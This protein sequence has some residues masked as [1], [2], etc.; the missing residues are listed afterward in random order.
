MN[1]LETALLRDDIT[2]PA[3]FWGGTVGRSSQSGAIDHLVIVRH[4]LNHGLV[5]LTPTASTRA[6]L[7]MMSADR[8]DML[9]TVSRELLDS[10][11][12]YVFYRPGECGPQQVTIPVADLHD[13]ARFVIGEFD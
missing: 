9:L 2:S 5:H 4:T 1:A 13:I 8:M 12:P 10:E 7:G 3:A 6:R 11:K